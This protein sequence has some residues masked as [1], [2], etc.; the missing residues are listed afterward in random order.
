MSGNYIHILL[1]ENNPGDARLIQEMLSEAKECPLS[2]ERR[3][4]NLICVNLLSKALAYL[5]NR[6]FDIILLDLLLPDSQGL[7]SFTR[8]YTYASSLPIIILTSLN[9]K[10]LIKK[11]IWSGAQDYL[12]KDRLNSDL[13]VRSICYSIE[14]KRADE[15]QKR[16]KDEYERN[17]QT[18][19]KQTLTELK[20]TQ[21][22]L[23]HS[24]K[25][26]SVGE[27][28]TGIAHEINNPACAIDNYLGIIKKQLTQFKNN[29]LI[30]EETYSKLLDTIDG[31]EFSLNRIKHTVDSIL[32]FSR[33][34]IENRVPYDIHKGIESTLTILSNQFKDGIEI[35]KEYSDIKEIEGDHQQLNQVFLNIISNA[36]YAINKKK[37][38]GLPCGKIKICSYKEGNFL[39]IRIK[40]DGIGIPK[41][42]RDKIF[43]PFFTTK[44][45]GEGTGLGLNICYK[46]INNHY[47]KIKVAS[48]IDKGST[49]TLTIPITQAK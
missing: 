12:T 21:A 3:T 32:N 29:P 26:A 20:E 41:N 25:L 46:I 13:L 24:A 30:F 27:L 1:I 22:E 8:L 38:K 47:G 23:F 35:Y 37:K 17:L 36:I 31:A 6:N 16:I 48:K 15:E 7:D 14:R 4:F 34:H 18:S 44:K 10:N 33:K 5:S 9:N 42:I 43:D 19:L 39:T 49:F 11:A 2:T 28:A 40:D 45:A